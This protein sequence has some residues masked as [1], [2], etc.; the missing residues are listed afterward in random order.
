MTVPMRLTATLSRSLACGLSLSTLLLAAC[1]TVGTVPIDDSARARLHVVSVNPVV[2]LPKD[3]T[4]LGPGEAAA[5]MLGGPLIGSLI[6]NGSSA[7]P[8][9]ALLAEL[10]KGHIAVGDIVAAEFARQA[11]DATKL[12]FVVDSQPADAQVE[13]WVNAYGIMHAQ[14]FGSTLYP[15]LNVS[16]VMRTPDGKVV[17]QATDIVGALN[18]EN[19]SGHTIDDYL[20]D[21]ELLRQA[22]T[23]GGDIVAHKLAD[24]FMGREKPQNVPGILQ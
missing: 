22:F 21:P 6:A 3:I 2:R 17:W 1:G 20:K 5:L 12:K 18:A 13:L 7:T 4:Y 8:K 11:G 23:A 10:D 15:M 24:N 19:R 16:A 14:P 9:A